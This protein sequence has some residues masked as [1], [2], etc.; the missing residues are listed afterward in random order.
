MHGM[1]SGRRYECVDGRPA[2]VSIGQV[3]RVGS[4]IMAKEELMIDFSKR[5]SR[6]FIL[7]AIDLDSRG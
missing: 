6:L 1:Y 3:A 7:V 4:I 2:N 5:K